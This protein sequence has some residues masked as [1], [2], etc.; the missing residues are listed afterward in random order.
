M[1][2]LDSWKCE[3]TEKANRECIVVAMVE[4]AAAK[5]G[6]REPATG[7]ASRTLCQRGEEHSTETRE[8]RNRPRQT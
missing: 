2:R 1:G 6:M 3:K 7:Y 8:K 4:M 5:V